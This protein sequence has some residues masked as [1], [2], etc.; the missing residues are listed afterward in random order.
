MKARR[1]FLA[2]LI[3][4]LLLAGAAQ[5]ATLNSPPLLVSGT[6][7]AECAAVNT[8]TTSIGSVT[9]DIVDLSSAVLATNTCATLAA[10]AAC[11][12]FAPASFYARCRITVSGGSPKKIRGIMDIRDSG[13]NEKV[14][15]EAR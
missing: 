2:A 13:N 1:L 8:G 5:G 7:F 11:Y 3:C 15:V 9:V 6:D 10:D 12:I 14:A 4:P